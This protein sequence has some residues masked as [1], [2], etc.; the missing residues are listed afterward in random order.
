M[1]R[2]LLLFLCYKLPGNPASCVIK[3][4]KRWTVAEIRHPAAMFCKPGKADS[5]AVPAFTP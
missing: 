2:P 4:K 5:A 3:T 1:V